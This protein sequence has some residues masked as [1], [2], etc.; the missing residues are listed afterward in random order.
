M[1]R[2]RFTPHQFL[3]YLTRPLSPDQMEIWVKANNIIPEKADLFFDFICSL[4]FLILETYLGDEVI[5]N[6]KDR[7]GHFNWCWKKTI[8]NFTRE[9]ISFAEDGMHYDYFWTFFDESFYEKNRDEKVWRMEEFFETLFKLYIQKT[10]SELD[11]LLD[12]YHAL[13]KHLTVNK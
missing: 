2:R 8:D 6:Q 11:I 4:Y 1:K 5:M 13:D 9:N 12:I 3:N 10:K 7:K